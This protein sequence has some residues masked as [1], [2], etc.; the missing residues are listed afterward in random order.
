MGAVEEPLPGR[1]EQ[2]PP[3]EPPKQL[4]P[5]LVFDL[6]ELMAQCRLG[7]VQPFDRRR[8]ACP[9]SRGSGPGEG[10]GSPS[11]ITPGSRRTG[12]TA[13]GRSPPQTAG[14]LVRR[15]PGRLQSRCGARPQRLPRGGTLIR[16]LGGSGRFECNS[17]SWLLPTK[18]GI[19][20]S[21]SG[22]PLC[23]IPMAAEGIIAGGG[24]YVAIHRQ[25]VGVGWPW[26]WR[27]SAVWWPLRH[28][29]APKE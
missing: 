21:K 17:P 7:E 29:R 13:G 4:D 14:R 1:G 12:A 19:E 23:R 18:T 15:G 22:A 8:S 2:H 3:L 28:R 10:D 16:S 5:E 9:R 11:P 24:A 25:S 20:S 26:W 6:F 27:P